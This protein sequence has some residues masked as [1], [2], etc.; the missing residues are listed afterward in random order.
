MTD[1]PKKEGIMSWSAKE[2]KRSTWTFSKIT[3]EAKKEK[4]N[5]NTFFNIGAAAEH[6]ITQRDFEIEKK[7][8]AN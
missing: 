8:C 6:V 5:P 2:L 4:K 3:A 1:T 7:L